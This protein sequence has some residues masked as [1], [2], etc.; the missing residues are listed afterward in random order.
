MRLSRPIGWLVCLVL[1]G[2]LCVRS[3]LKAALS[4]ADGDEPSA[5]SITRREREQ[6]LSYHESLLMRIPLV[7]MFMPADAFTG[8]LLHQI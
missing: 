5:I 3:P 1:V 8:I 2:Y 6:K 7:A 4:S